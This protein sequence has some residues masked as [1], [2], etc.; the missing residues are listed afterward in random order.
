MCFQCT[1]FD[2]VIYDVSRFNIRSE[3]RKNRLINLW[4]PHSTVHFKISSFPQSVQSVLVMYRSTSL[5]FKSLCYCSYTVWSSNHTLLKVKYIIQVPFTPTKIFITS[6]HYSLCLAS[7][8]LITLNIRKSNLMI[9]ST[10]DFSTFISVFQT[11]LVKWQS[12][13]R[14]QTPS[15]AI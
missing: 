12:Y 2:P 4:I 6:T 3:Q 7:S 13:F 1:S 5:C 11:V 14:Y 8:K 15:W 9:I 10:S